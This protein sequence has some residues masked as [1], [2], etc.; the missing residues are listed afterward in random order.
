VGIWR[1]SQINQPTVLEH[2][3]LLA[4]KST[5]WFILDPAMTYGA[6]GARQRRSTC[7]RE[8]GSDAAPNE[9]A[10]APTGKIR[11]G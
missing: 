2:G 8:V 9:N 6:E 7:R 4:S 10:A 5:E 11:R 1:S 3:A